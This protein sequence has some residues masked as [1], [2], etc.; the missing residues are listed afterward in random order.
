MIDIGYIFAKDN[1]RVF[2]NT[3]LGCKG[4]CCY[5][6]LSKLGYNN[7]SKELNTVTAEYVLEELEKFNLNINIETLI[8]LGCY[9]ECWDNNNK[10]QT[11]KLIKYFLQ[12]G[13][14]VQLSTKKQITKEELEDVIPLIKYNGQLVIFISVATISKHDYLE[15]NT[16]KIEDRFKTF[17]NL[18]GL[19]IPTVLYI[20]PV[21]KNI[22]LQDLPLFKE[23]IKQYGIKEVVVGSMFTNKQSNE[24]VP[25]LNKESLFY[26]EVDDE[27]V[28]IDELK[29]ITNVYKRSTQVTK[30]YKQ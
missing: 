13:N 18:K 17:N 8:T 26:N 14:Q 16:T 20:K 27:K 2:L 24:A 7:N 15:S 6:Y 28:I 22:T 5:C 11:L 3:S 1:K 4:N 19:S 12:K 9:S 30:K 23:C 25:F 10:Q 21:I 29:Q